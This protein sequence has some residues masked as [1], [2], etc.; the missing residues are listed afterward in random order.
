MKIS[1][2]IEG[3]YMDSGLVEEGSEMAASCR[4]WELQVY[5]ER[6]DGDWDAEKLLIRRK[7]LNVCT[8]LLS[9]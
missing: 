3:T 1:G 4:L 2:R 5:L 9:E 6:R 8:V 7:L